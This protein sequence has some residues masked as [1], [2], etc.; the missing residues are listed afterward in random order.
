MFDPVITHAVFATLI[1]VA[2][3]LLANV[4]EPV[5]PLAMKV[6]VSPHEIVKALALKFMKVKT[7]PLI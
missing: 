1:A 4:L 7:V 6:I 3:P 5:A 2:I